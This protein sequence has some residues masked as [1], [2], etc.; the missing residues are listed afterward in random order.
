MARTKLVARIIQDQIWRT[1]QRR[2]N[3]KSSRSGVK[4]FEGTIRNRDLKIKQPIP[5]TKTFWSKK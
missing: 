2:P 5:Q 4:N 1:S 3:P